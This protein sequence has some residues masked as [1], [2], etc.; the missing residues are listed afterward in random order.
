MKEAGLG[1]VGIGYIGKTHLRNCLNLK[2]SRLVA[3]A[4]V[5]QKALNFAKEM[6]VKKTYGDYRQLLKDDQ[7]D[8]VIIALPTYLHED[9]AKEAAEAR[10]DIFLEKPLARNATE[11]NRI[12]STAK[13]CGVKL[14]VGYP[15]RFVPS[16][17]SLKEKISSGVVG[18]VQTAYASMINEGPFFHRAE[19]HMPH[20]VPSW[21]F[22]K[23]LTGGG[24]LIDQGSHLINLLRWYFGGVADI[25]CHFGYRFNLSVED[26]AICILKFKNETTAIV[27]VG[28][29]SMSNQIKVELLGS[30]QHA[31]AYHRS[32]SKIT[33]GLQLLAGITPKF[34]VPYFLELQHFVDSIKQDL[35]PVPSGEDALEDVRVISMAYEKKH[36]RMFKSSLAEDEDL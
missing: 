36:A 15:L 23:E 12:V 14:M 5:S 34:Y 22:D 3:V 7:V 9:C 24:S 4:D 13:K 32:S 31:F 29:Y 8:A 35:Q 21:W 28:W 11:G 6:G 17:C 27:N 10:K 16:F 19:S 26:H 1:L 2:S 20:P 18:D 30:V 33:I 25:K